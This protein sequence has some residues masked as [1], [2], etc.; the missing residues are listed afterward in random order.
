MATSLFSLLPT[1]A[2]V[3]LLAG[4]NSN[5][6]PASSI[7]AESGGDLRSEVDLMTAV[8]LTA[9]GGRFIKLSWLAFYRRL[10]PPEPYR[11]ILYGVAIATIL[12]ST[13]NSLVSASLHTGRDAG[14]GVTVLMRNVGD[15][16]GDLCLHTDK[17]RMGSDLTRSPL[18][19]PPRGNSPS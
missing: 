11:K 5:T 13:A 3:N 7:L 4:S 2:A 9:V 6:S 18:Q 16:D 17:S 8:E 15:I 1:L 12:F 19:G 10:L 14:M